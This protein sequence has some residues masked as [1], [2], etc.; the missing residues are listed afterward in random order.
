MSSGAESKSPECLHFS[1]DSKKKEYRAP[2]LFEYGT[3]RD[4]THTVGGSGKSDSTSKF[5]PNKTSV[6]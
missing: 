4:L 6:Q 5:F 3:L 2:Q 1:S